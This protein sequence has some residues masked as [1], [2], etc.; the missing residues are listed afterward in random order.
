M[1]ECYCEIDFLRSFVNNIP[2]ADPYGENRDFDIWRNFKKLIFEYSRL[3]IDN[4]NKLDAWV[5]EE[6]D[7]K[8]A[9]ILYKMKLSAKIEEK[10]FSDIQF[11]TVN[12]HTVFF[13]TDAQKCKEMEEDYG[14]LFICDETKID[15]AKIIFEKKEVS[16]NK[17]G[18][19][20]NYDFLRKYRH[21]CNCLII[22]DMYLLGETAEVDRKSVV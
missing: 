4:G 13:L 5:N 2:E 8:L 19:Y 21:P 10:Q 7:N 11:E 15:K 3:S 1:T 18:V 17:N 16:V 22:N 20:R 6:R 14:M 9:M 12:P